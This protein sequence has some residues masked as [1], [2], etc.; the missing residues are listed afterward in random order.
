MTTFLITR[1][2]RWRKN[3]LKGLFDLVRLGQVRV[4]ITSSIIQNTKVPIRLLACF[5]R[6]FERTIFVSFLCLLLTNVSFLCN[7]LTNVSFWCNLL[8]NVSFW[9]NLEAWGLCTSFTETGLIIWCNLLTNVCLFW[10][11][12]RPLNEHT[13]SN[14][15]EGVIGVVSKSGRGGVLFLCFISFF[16]TKVFKVFWGGTWGAFS[17]PSPLCP[18]ACP[19]M[20]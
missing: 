18:W 3:G 5:G 15:F 8:T 2:L 16:M 20:H 11:K 9:C 4:A 1:G 12:L 19:L 17:S 13:F 7:L 10:Q 14:S 6:K